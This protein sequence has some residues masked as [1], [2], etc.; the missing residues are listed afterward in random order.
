MQVALNL[1]KK[2]NGITASNPSVGCVITKD[3]KII[4]T[5]TTAVSGRPH[6]ES[7]ALSLNYDFTGSSMF[8][9]LEPCSHFGKTSPCVE[10]IIKAGI[11][12]VFIGMQDPDTRVNGI[13]IETLKKAGIEVFCGLLEAEV[14]Q[15]Y[16]PYVFF[17]TNKRPF[18]TGK[19]ACSMDGKIATFSHESKWITSPL[20][21]TFTNF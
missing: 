18:V 11:K 19:I 6:A 4:S 20:Q 2:H 14:K 13:G 21:N 7:V 3:G 10:K 12:Q 9:T 8:V 1:A 17:K 5:A 16:K 15:F